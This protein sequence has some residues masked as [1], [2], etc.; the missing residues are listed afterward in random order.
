MTPEWK[1]VAASF[2]LTWLTLGGYALYLAR[3]IRRAESAAREE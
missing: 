1:F 3:R 2:A